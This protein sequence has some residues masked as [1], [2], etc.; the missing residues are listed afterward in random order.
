MAGE[1]LQ[2]VAVGFR[3]TAVSRTE[4]RGAISVLT[5]FLF[6]VLS[7]AAVHLCHTVSFLTLRQPWYNSSRTSRSYFC[8]SYE[9]CFCVCVCP[10]VCMCACHSEHKLGDSNPYSSAYEKHTRSTAAVAAA[11]AAVQHQRTSHRLIY[12]LVDRNA[13]VH[14]FKLATSPGRKCDGTAKGYIKNQ[15][16]WNEEKENTGIRFNES[17]TKL[18]IRHTMTNSSRKQQHCSCCCSSNNNIQQ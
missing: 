4:N 1:L 8:D 16:C 15:S 10:Y 18:A 7:A 11:I 9:L 6:A 13:C 17:A 12:T 2:H 3:N 5:T 14:P